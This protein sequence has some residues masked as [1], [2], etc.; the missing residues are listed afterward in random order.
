VSISFIA[1]LM[2]IESDLQSLVLESD[3]TTGDT[4]AEAPV[5]AKVT[6]ARNHIFSRIEGFILE[7]CFNILL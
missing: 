7:L 4:N 5:I 3:I 1:V 2:A 6:H